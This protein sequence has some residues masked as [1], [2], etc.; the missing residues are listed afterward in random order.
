MNSTSIAPMPIPVPSNFPVIWEHPEDANLF[1][2]LDRMHFP[3]A[4]TPMTGQYIDIFLLSGDHVFG[5]LDLPLRMASRRINTYHYHA[6]VPLLLPAHEMAEQMRRADVKMQEVIEQLDEQWTNV[7]LPEIKHHLAYWRDFDLATAPL[8]ELVAHLADTL[9]RVR[10]LSQIHHL[11]QMTSVLVPSLFHDFYVDLFGDDARVGDTKQALEV[12]RLLQGFDNKTLA[13]DHALRQLSRQ[14][15]ASP[16]VYRTLQESAAAGVLIALE[17]SPEGRSFLTA[18]QVY[19]DLYGQRSTKMLELDAPTWIEDPTPSIRILQAYITQPDRDPVAERAAQIVERERLL[20]ET[21][22]RLQNYPQPIVEQFEFLLKV[23]QVGIFLSEEH[24]YWIDQRMT[25]AVRRVMLEFGRRFAAAS[26]LDRPD[27]VFYLTF[28]EVHT[29][30]TELPR[31]DQR[32][33]VAG[34]RAEMEYFRTVEPPPALGALPSGPPPD[35][36]WSRS[37]LRFWG[38]PPPAST[39][40]VLLRG[41]GASP[42]IVQGRAKVVHSFTEAGKLQKG[43]VLITESTSP[44]WTLLFATAAAVVTDTGGIL[45]HAAITAR[46]YR[47]P[48]VVGTGVATKLIGDGQML[49]VNGSNGLVRIM[50]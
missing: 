11:V 13:G 28:D 14:A 38:A 20:A 27:D 47:I 26:V 40:P 35:D 1:W 22:R 48:A 16:A 5:L 24:N 31:L 29:T 42:G 33:L 37:D 43:D 9:V 2:V 30:A 3:T 44:V 7:Y 23:A 45:S 8:P 21:R 15:L 36:A 10:R 17:A 18:L 46:E 34:R 41:H 32:R 50:V 4:I 49:E 12:Y 25:Y 6:T 19:L 39:D